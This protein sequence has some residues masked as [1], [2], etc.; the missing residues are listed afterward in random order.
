[1][2]LSKKLL[3][4]FACHSAAAAQLLDV[5][6]I[7]MHLYR[8]V[9]NLTTNLHDTLASDDAAA[10][11]PTGKDSSS[12]LTSST[13][14]SA[15]HGATAASHA[16]ISNHRQHQGEAR[17]TDSSWEVEERA[18]VVIRLRRNEAA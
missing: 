18:C 2:P 9:F 8:R 4:N 1:M 13:R 10:D 12:F 6:T 15:L 7:F 16:D 17:K 3:L 5:I 14:R 11:A